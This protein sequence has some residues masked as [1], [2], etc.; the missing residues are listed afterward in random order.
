MRNLAL[1]LEYDGTAFL[2]WQVQATGRT[3]QGTVE[4]ALRTILQEDVRLIAAGRT[5]TGVHATGQIANF[6]THALIPVD[7]LRSGLNSLLP[8]D[9]VVHEAREVDEQFH[10]RYSATGRAYR[11]RILR[12]PSALRHRYTWYIDYPLDVPAIV[13]ASEVLVGLHDF[14]SFCQADASRSHARCHV[15]WLRWQEVED[16]LVLDIEADRFLH[17]MVRTIVGTAVDIGRGHRAAEDIARMLSACDRRT[18]GLT[19]PARGLCLVSV[20]YKDSEE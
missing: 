18:A 1:T 13:Q 6:R 19:A 17:H 3:V 20:T 16:E 10:A 11:Y 12:R 2:G 5:D 4:T 15:R 7:R 8:R 14:T 9:V